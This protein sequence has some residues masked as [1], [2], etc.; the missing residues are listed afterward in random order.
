MN[1]VKLYC[2]VDSFVKQINNSSRKKQVGR[3]GI[4]SKTDYLFLCIIKQKRGFLTTKEFYHFI[5]E[6]VKNWFNELPS[7]KQFIKGI[8]KSLKYLVLLTWVLA[9]MNKMKKSKYHIVDSMPLPVCNNQYRFRSKIYK[10]FASSGKN[11]NGWYYGFKLHLIINLNM[12]IES[13]HISDGSTKDLNVL[14]TAFTKDIFGWLVGDKGYIGKENASSLSDQ[15]IT[16]ITKPRTN[17][18]KPP[19]TR[20]QQFLIAQR[21]KIES[22]NSS[23]KH[24]LSIINRY[25][26]SLDSFFVSV[27]A[28]ISAYSLFLKSNLKSNPINPV[29]FNPLIS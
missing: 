11:M 3:K 10:N 13:V 22:V 9:R 18:K 21:Q 5:K 24:R 29:F 19:A 28:S 7:Y 8:E 27:F 4:L 25:A 6:D 12:E 14:G 23:L 15:G 16:L 2:L 1:T 17:M 26:R 20:I